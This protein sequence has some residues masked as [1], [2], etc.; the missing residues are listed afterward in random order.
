MVDLQH[1]YK[2]HQHIYQKA[3]VKLIYVFIICYYRYKLGLVNITSTS[4]MYY[5][6]G[7]LLLKQITSTKKRQTRGNSGIDCLL[8]LGFKCFL[9]C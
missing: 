1:N 8:E 4:E 2:F 3:I 7:F 9:N 6:S 5:P